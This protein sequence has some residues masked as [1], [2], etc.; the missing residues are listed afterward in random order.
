M[1]IVKG[2]LI[3]EDINIEE[4]MA[5]TYCTGGGQLTR[6]NQLM[7]QSQKLNLTIGGARYIESVGV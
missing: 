1:C 2:A 6:I 3:P 5:F 4:D 7:Y